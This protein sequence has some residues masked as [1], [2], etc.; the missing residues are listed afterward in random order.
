MSRL[1]KRAN[2]EF[3]LN[4][5]KSRF[6]L[7]VEQRFGNTSSKPIMIE[8][9]SREWMELLNLNEVRSIMLTQETN[10][11]DEINNL[12]MNTYQHKMGIFAKLM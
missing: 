3:S 5:K 1:R 12:F 8:E 7:I 4:D 9:V 10:N 6:S 11:F 2:H